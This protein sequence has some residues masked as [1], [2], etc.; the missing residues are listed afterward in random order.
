MLGELMTVDV[1][2]ASAHHIFVFTLVALIGVELTLL[3]RGIEQRTAVVI[4]RVDSVLG[5]SAILILLAGFLRVFVGIKPEAFYLENPIFWAKIA[6]FIGV[7][8]ISILPTIR[9][10]RW[11]R[12][13]VDDDSFNPA[14]TE[15]ATVRRFVAAELVV[16]V[17]IPIFAALM[18]RGYGL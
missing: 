2:L 16:L 11:S 15:V 13:A 18:A 4:A 3:Y 8:L 6:A 10:A 14:P 17:L 12:L 5:L 9:F 7:A 1:I